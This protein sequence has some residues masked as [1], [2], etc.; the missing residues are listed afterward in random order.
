MA[1]KYGKTVSLVYL[2]LITSLLLQSLPTLALPS[3]IRPRHDSKVPLLKL[4]VDTDAPLVSG[5]VVVGVKAGLPSCWTY[6]PFPS[7]PRSAVVPFPTDSQAPQAT[8]TIVI[9]VASGSIPQLAQ[10]SVGPTNGVEVQAKGGQ[11]T[12]SKDGTHHISEEETF[13]T[14][15]AVPDHQYGA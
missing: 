4:C 5:K 11:V 12:Q 6:S 8:L 15:F 13:K 1:Q 3:P 10:Q 7:T 2:S 14:T 9:P